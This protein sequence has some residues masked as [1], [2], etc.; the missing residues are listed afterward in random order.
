[1]V[2]PELFCNK[3]NRDDAVVR[4]SDGQLQKFVLAALKIVRLIRKFICEEVGA[5]L[6]HEL[7]VQLLIEER[8]PDNR[9]R[10]TPHYDFG[11]DVFV[12]LHEVG[13]L[14]IVVVEER[15]IAIIRIACVSLE[16]A[17]RLVV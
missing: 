9:L 12:V 2:V 4:G 3:D 13:D 5:I 14:I 11:L 7:L 10:T 17:H 1:M 8:Q 15:A 16:A 6:L